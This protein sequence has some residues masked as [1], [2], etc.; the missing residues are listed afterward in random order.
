MW[1]SFVYQTYNDFKLLLRRLISLHHGV[2][3]QSFFSVECRILLTQCFKLVQTRYHIDGH[4]NPFFV[5]TTIRCKTNTQCTTV[6]WIFKPLNTLHFKTKWSP[7]TK[8]FK[9]S[10]VTQLVKRKK[11]KEIKSNGRIKSSLLLSFVREHEYKRPSR[12]N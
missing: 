2:S 7:R 9:L 12:T 5:E 10:Q 6:S 11:E 1:L 8:Y 4:I 3:A